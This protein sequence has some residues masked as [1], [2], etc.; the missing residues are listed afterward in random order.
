MTASL[1]IRP[2]ERTNAPCLTCDQPGELYDFSVAA[3][4][5]MTQFAAEPVE[6]NDRADRN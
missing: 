1:V 4:P 3:S 2:L 5:E 6:E